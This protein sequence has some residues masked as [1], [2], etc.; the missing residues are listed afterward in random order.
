MHVSE[1]HQIRFKE[2]TQHINTR[3]LGEPCNLNAKET[4]SSGLQVRNRVR[5]RLL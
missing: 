3:D 4:S 2:N 1:N 5:T